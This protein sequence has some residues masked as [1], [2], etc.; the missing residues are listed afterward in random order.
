MDSLISVIVPVYNVDAYLG[1]CIES[2]INQTYKNIEIIL[3][4]DGSTDDSGNICDD[5]ALLDDRIKVFHTENHGVTYARKKGVKSAKGAFIG[6]VDGDDYIDSNYY[7]LLLKKI[8]S[9]N[10]DFVQMGFICEHGNGKREVAIQEAES[11][12]IRGKQE[13]VFFEGVWELLGGKQVSNMLTYSLCVRLFRA[14]MIRKCI[15][16]I[17]DNLIYGEDMACMC[18]CILHSNAYA[19]VKKSGYHYVQRQS[20]A[21]HV[22][23]IDFVVNNC[24]LYDYIV[25]IFTCTSH[26]EKARQVMEQYLV[27]ELAGVWGN[28]TGR[29]IAMYEFPDVKMLSG[30]KTVLYGAGKVGTDYYRQLCRYEKCSVVAFAD[31]H[32]EKYTYDYVTV[33]GPEKIK[34]L[35]WDVLVLSVMKQETAQQIRNFLIDQGVDGEKIYWCKPK[36]IYAVE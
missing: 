7:E 9:D 2:I 1:K 4:D 36:R 22:R 23:N 17:P 10:Y 5:F 27:H 21:V 33:I 29:Y 6:F 34:E 15:N 19:A 24:K 30:K 26:Y 20:S 18:W 8:T 14:D 16:L 35:D 31:T 13:A 32:F 3:I 28:I 11:Y 25:S 12:D